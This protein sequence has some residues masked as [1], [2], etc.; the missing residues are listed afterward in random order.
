MKRIVSQVLRIFNF[1]FGMHEVDDVAIDA[2]T[3]TGR[4]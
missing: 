2:K 1:Y 4:V 3:L